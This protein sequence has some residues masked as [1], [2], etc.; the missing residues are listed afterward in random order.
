MNTNI[1]SPARNGVTPTRSFPR[2]SKLLALLRVESKIQKMNITMRQ[3]TSKSVFLALL[4]GL[5]GSLPVEAGDIFYLVSNSSHGV[6]RKCVNPAG[7]AKNGSRL[8]LWGPIPKGHGPRYRFKLVSAG[9]EGNKHF[10]YLLNTFSGKYMCSGDTKDGGKLWLWGPI[11]KGD[12]ARYQFR[13]INTG[14]EGVYNIWHKFSG[15]YVGY[16]A[17]EKNGSELQLGDPKKGGMRFDFQFTETEP[18]PAQRI[19]PG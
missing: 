6:D 11:P 10:D 5:I 8:W 3:F 17:E 7:D 12:E 18:K 14:Q 19:D 1:T 4:L 2:G 13:L 15:K 16:V 9:D